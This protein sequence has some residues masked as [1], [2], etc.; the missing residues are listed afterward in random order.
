VAVAECLKAQ[1]HAQFILREQIYPKMM[2]RPPTSP[3]NVVLQ[4]VDAI[5][6]AARMP[7]DVNDG[8]TI[9]ID[10]FKDKSDKLGRYHHRAFAKDLEGYLMPVA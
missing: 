2:Q 4:Q 5:L 10:Y 8:L 1:D 6:R 3:S 9:A 7:A